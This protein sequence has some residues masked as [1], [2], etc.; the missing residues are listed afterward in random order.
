MF[1]NDSSDMNCSLSAAST[2]S[3]SIDFNDVRRRMP[4]YEHRVGLST[5]KRISCASIANRTPNDAIK[6]Q[7]EVICFQNPSSFDRDGDHQYFDQYSG[8][9]YLE[10]SLKAEAFYRE[11]ELELVHIVG[12][13]FVDQGS[14]E[15][16]E[17]FDAC[18]H[19]VAE[20]SLEIMR[21]RAAKQS[22]SKMKILNDFRRKFANPAMSTNDFHDSRNTAGPPS[23]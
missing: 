18:Y 6:H 19:S 5:S 14:K 10:D 2:S 22:K 11:H 15:A 12:L 9:E 23:A 3:S 17:R 7:S 8:F 4:E 1:M 21:R 20:D 13:D 16:N